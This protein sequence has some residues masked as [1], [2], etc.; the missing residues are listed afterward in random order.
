[1][2]LCRRPKLRTGSAWICD[3]RLSESSE[4]HGRASNFRN[5][6]Y[7]PFHKYIY[8]YIHTVYVY[9][10]DHSLVYIYI[11]ISMLYIL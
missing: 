9:I 7:N 3:L 5:V 6:V 4:G 10:Y 2:K 1:M 11:I 8:I